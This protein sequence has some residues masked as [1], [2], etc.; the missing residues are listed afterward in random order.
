MPHM[1]KT[2]FILM[3]AFSALTLNSC[4]EGYNDSTPQLQTYV[5]EHNWQDSV[6]G[7]TLRCKF[8][9]DE[10]VMDTIAV[11][12][13]VRFLVYA[14]A[15]ANNLV[16][17]VFNYDAAVVDLTFPKEKMTKEFL[18]A[19]DTTK[20]D[21]AHGKYYFL[22][23]YNGAAVEVKYR[24]LVVGSHSISIAVK[25]DANSERVPNENS[26]NFKQPTR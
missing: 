22:P 3:L 18:A 25:S 15:F 6:A 14:N 10:Y 23:G 21:I 7:D 26:L 4:L 2:F 1:K 24:P 17:L 8:E 20:T 16:S 9:K 13:S 12:D 19:L 5:F 11:G